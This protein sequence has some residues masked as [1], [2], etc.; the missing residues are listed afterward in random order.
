MIPFQQLSSALLELALS[1]VSAV[2]VK[3]KCLGATT[4]QPQ[5]GRPH[6]L[7]ERD[8]RVLKCVKIVCPRLQYS[9]PSS[10]LPLEE[11]S[12]QELFIES[13]MKWVS[14][15]EQPHTSLRS[16]CAMSSIGWKGVKLVGLWKLVL[17]SDESLF[18]IWQSDGQIWF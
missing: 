8:H 6:K 11:T 4:A 12:A 1:N 17:W 10:K 13:F 3:L 14:M 2:I 18:S 9:L 7:A 5:S 15:A 16:P